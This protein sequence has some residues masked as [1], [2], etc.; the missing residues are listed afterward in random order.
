VGKLLPLGYKL[1]LKGL[2]KV[3]ISTLFLVFGMLLRL[4]IINPTFEADRVANR[5]FKVIIDLELRVFRAYSP[6]LRAVEF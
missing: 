4:F 2:L 1:S 5:H 3:E 6:D